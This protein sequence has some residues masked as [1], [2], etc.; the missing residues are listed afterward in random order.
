MKRLAIFSG[1]G[2]TGKT[3]LA[4]SLTEL[5]PKAVAADCDVDAA[6]LALLLHGDDEAI[7]PFFA[8]QKATIDPDRCAGCGLCEARCRFDAI[9]WDDSTSAFRVVTAACEGCG[10]CGMVC[11]SSGTITFSDNQAGTWTRRQLGDK[12]ALVHAELGVAQDNSGKLVAVVREEAEKMADEADV[13]LII[14]DGPPGI[15]CP[16]HAA[17][18]RVDLAVAVTEPTV[19]GERDLE[20]FLDTAKHFEVPAAV[21]INKWDLSP[22]GADR[23]AEVCKARGID[24]IGRIPFDEAMPRMLAK[25]QVP[26]TTPASDVTRAAFAAIW[27]EVSERL[28]LDL[29]MAL[30]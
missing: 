23:I 15:G 7:R 16:V 1:K 4:A 24:V 20:R 12:H 26:L 11:P 10:V 21:V 3:T 30:D 9:E 19:S 18:G 17:I 8:G 14:I 28:N 25:G 5:A 13:P 27:D 6:N 2:G 22:K 29:M